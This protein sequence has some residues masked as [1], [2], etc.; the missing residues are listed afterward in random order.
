MKLLHR[1]SLQLFT[2]C[3]AL[4]LVGG[5]LLYSWMHQQIADE[6]YE[7]LDFE[8]DLIR[9]ELAAGRTVSFPFVTVEEG[10]PAGMATQ[11]GDTLVYDSVQ[12]LTEGYYYLKKTELIHGK[13]VRISVMTTYIGWTEYAR[14]IFYTMLV[15]AFLF[16]LLGLLINHYINRRLW[17]PFFSNLRLL[18]RFSVRSEAPVP[19]EPSRITEFTAL[20]QT[21][22]EMTTRS[23]REY[24]ALREFSENASHEIQTPLSIMRSSLEKLSQQPVDEAMAGALVDAKGALDR[25]SAVNRKL[26]LLARLDNNYYA[27]TQPVDLSAL[28]R[29]KLGAV[30]DVIHQKGIALD[31][32]IHGGVVVSSDPYVAETLVLNL[33]SNLLRYTPRGG[34]AVITLTADRLVFANT[35]VPLPFAPGLLF[36]RFKKGTAGA[37]SG[38]HSNGLGLA[39]VKRVCETNHWHIS[40]SYRQETHKLTVGFGGSIMEARKSLFGSP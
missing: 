10:V 7:Q 21:L 2:L 5:S 13:P 32:S 20:Q 8:I 29:A 37:H 40:Y 24:V 9:K 6:I 33:L 35:G 11:F 16:C 12:Q 23:R 28:L 1:T 34:R 30:E 25:L 39:I 3:A 36:E 26:L 19:W 14:M 4:L 15:V 18:R 17:G 27:D 31:T 22:D 38:S